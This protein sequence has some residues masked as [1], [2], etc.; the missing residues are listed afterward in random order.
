MN[1]LFTNRNKIALL[2]A[3]LFHAVGFA[4]IVFFDA[5][6]FAKT[7]VYHLLLMA[8]LLFYTHRKINLRFVVF[9]AICFCAGILLEWYGSTTGELFGNY[10]YSDVLGPGIAN[11]PF[12][13]GIN[14]FIVIYCC[15]NLVHMAFLKLYAKLPEGVVFKRNKLHG[16]S[17]VIDGALVAVFTDFLLEPVA[18]KLNYWQWENNVVPFYNYVCWFVAGAALLAVFRWLKVPGH[19]IFAVHLLLIQWLFFL[20]VNAFL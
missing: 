1:N 7:S 2:V 6:V 15:S 8:A 17:I 20:L 5:S 13:M 4:G 14:W 11:V 16:L 3:I 10:T 9:F 18:I 12:V 19:N